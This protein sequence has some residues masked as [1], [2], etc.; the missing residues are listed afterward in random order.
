MNVGI[1]QSWPLVEEADGMEEDRR[2]RL[3]L[4][5]RSNYVP[6]ADCE[7]YYLVDLQ[8]RFAQ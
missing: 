1:F 4:M 2:K 3:F 8:G 7:S 6:K 5:S